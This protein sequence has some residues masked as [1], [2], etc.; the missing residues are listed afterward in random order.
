MDQLT[1]AVGRE[2]PV[3]QRGAQ[4]WLRRQDA[5]EPEQR[6]LDLVELAVALGAHERRLDGEVLDGVDDVTRLRPAG[7]GELLQ[8]PQRRCGDTIT[9]QGL[10]EPLLGPGLDRRVGKRAPEAAFG[11]E[12]R[13]DREQLVGEMLELRRG[14]ALGDLRQLLAKPSE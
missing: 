10:D 9:E 3:G 6:V 5:L 11:R 13:H 7:P 8:Q 12:Q 14:A 4:R 1:L 2:H